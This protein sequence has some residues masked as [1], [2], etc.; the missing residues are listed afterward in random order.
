MKKR[1]FLN[2]AP[3]FEKS[4]F[5]WINALLL[6]QVFK[7]DKVLRV[8]FYTFSIIVIWFELYQKMS[9]HKLHDK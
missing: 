5:L 2:F 1:L 8:F 3:S 7:D 6:N 4:L 9:K